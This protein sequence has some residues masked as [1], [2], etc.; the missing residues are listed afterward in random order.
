MKLITTDQYIQ[1]DEVVRNCL[2][3]ID[4]LAEPFMP[5]K[6]RE[7]QTNRAQIVF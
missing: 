1:N 2:N 4:P 7:D 5:R 6:E 3:F